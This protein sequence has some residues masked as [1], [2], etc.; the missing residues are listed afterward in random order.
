MI[1]NQFRFCVQVALSDKTNR[2]KIGQEMREKKQF[3]L[4]WNKFA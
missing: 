3:F 2:M 4:F 1:I